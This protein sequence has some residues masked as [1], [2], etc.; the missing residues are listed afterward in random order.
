MNGSRFHLTSKTAIVRPLLKKPCLDQNCLQNY[1]LVL[2][3]SFLS[4][5]LEKIVLKQL[6]DH[7]NLYSLISLPT[8][9]P[10]VLRLSFKP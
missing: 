5:A 2:N 9:L 10:T 8:E 3:L 1:C 6:L 7:L 4:K